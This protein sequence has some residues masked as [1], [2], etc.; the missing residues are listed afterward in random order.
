[1]YYIVLT[2]H[3][4][5]CLFLIL[6]VLLQAGRGSGMGGLFGG[7]GEALLSAPSGS[8]FIKKLTAIVAL[9]FAFTSLFLTVLTARKNYR[10]VLERVPAPP[11]IETPQLPQTPIQ[12]PIET[13]QK[14]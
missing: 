2:L 6:V 11:P 3:V 8:A 10:T 12:A 7:G 9:S 14:K 5:V 1:M 13:P 4:V